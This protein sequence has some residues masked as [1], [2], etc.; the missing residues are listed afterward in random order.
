MLF[1]NQPPENEDRFM[2]SPITQ[3]AV[4]PLPVNMDRNTRLRWRRIHHSNLEIVIRRSGNHA[5]T[6][7]RLSFHFRVEGF[8]VGGLGWGGLGGGFNGEYRVVLD[9]IFGKTREELISAAE[10]CSV[11]VTE[12]GH[13]C[14]EEVCVRRLGGDEPRCRSFAAARR[15][16]NRMRNDPVPK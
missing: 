8:S 9:V 15:F 13:A 16:R 12:G 10:D 1:I 4:Y 3:P 7:R 11:K 2:L 5:L 14:F 6:C